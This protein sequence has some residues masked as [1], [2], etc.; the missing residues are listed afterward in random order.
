MSPC[1]LLF[2]LFLALYHLTWQSCDVSDKGIKR[3]GDYIQ[4]EGAHEAFVNNVRTTDG[5]NLT[6]LDLNN[7]I[8]VSNCGGTPSPNIF[9]YF[10]RDRAWYCRAGC[11]P[12]YGAQ[13]KISYSDPLLSQEGWS[14]PIRPSTT[15]E[16]IIDCADG[17][18][19]VY[20]DTK[21]VTSSKCSAETGW[22]EV[23]AKFITCKRGCSN[24]MTSIKNTI[25]NT[26]A[27]FT[28]GEVYFKTGDE[29]NF[30]CNL[31]YTMVGESIM[32]CNSLNNWH[33]T[34]PECL[35]LG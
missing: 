5:L 15:A 35:N 17:Y 6:E 30:S 22:S 8:K 9:K 26:T 24:I 33:S 16:A 21:T 27:S 31:G 29:I 19:K 13:W 2:T 11:A 4:C 20:Q 25:T 23:P 18:G 14:P 1:H 7:R 28:K 3:D 12:F 10:G 34:L 32:T